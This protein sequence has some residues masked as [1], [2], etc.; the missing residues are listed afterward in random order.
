MKDDEYDEMGKSSEEINITE[1]THITLSAIKYPL[2][3]LLN[4]WQ[5]NSAKSP[6]AYSF[7]KHFL[8]VLYIIAHASY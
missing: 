8:S 3:L 6:K 4:Q 1:A 5:G 2:P 7:N